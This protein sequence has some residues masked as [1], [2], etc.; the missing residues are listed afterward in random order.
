[1]Q[2]HDWGKANSPHDVTIYLPEDQVLFS[3]DMLVQ[4]PLPYLGA[5]WPVPWIEVLRQIEA[6]P[7]RALVPGHGPVMK[8]HA[9]TRQVRGLLEAATSRVEA[10][11]REGLTL[12]QA[13]GSIDLLDLRTG[14]WDTGRPEDR[15]D[16]KTIVKTLVERAWRGVRGQG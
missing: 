5:S 1:V 12:E 15:E 13:Q 2:L 10:K 3:G 11:L 9:Y 14:A 16:W 7:I 4:S 8:D 6:L